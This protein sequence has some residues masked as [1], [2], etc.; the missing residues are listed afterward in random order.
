[1]SMRGRWYRWDKKPITDEVLDLDMIRFAKVV[2]LT[3]WLVG[4]W[5]WT[6]TSSHKASIGYTIAP[7]K[8]VWLR[9]TVSKEQ[10]YNY[11]AHTTTTVQPFGGVRYWW[12]CPNCSQRVRILY[13]TGSFFVCRRCAG[14]YYGT[15]Q[16]K[17]LM[18]RIDNELSRIRRKLKA[19]GGSVADT[20][21]PPKPK[22]MHWTTYSRLAQR[23]CGF[24]G[25]ASAP[26]GQ[27]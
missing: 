11:L 4:A 17:S 14:V 12:L 19:T 27:R 5:Q 18:M 21:P 10:E 20:M 7:G 23:G 1:M 3:R 25:Y 16:N 13:G 6:W 8:G 9:Y 24:S 15:Q 2:D 26:L 22:G